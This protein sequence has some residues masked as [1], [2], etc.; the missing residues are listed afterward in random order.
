MPENKQELEQQAL[1]L[2]I[3]FMEDPFQFTPNPQ[4]DM[5]RLEETTNVWL[6]KLDEM[7]DEN[8]IQDLAYHHFLL[9][10][11]DSL[12]KRYLL[13]EM[14]LPKTAALQRI[15]Q[16]WQNPKIIASQVS[17][18]TSNSTEIYDEISEMTYQL[19]PEDIDYLKEEDWI[20]GIAIPM[21]ISYENELRILMAEVL[22]ELAGAQLI[23]V[24]E[25]L[26][27][28]YNKEEVDSFFKRY[29]V[30]VYEEFYL[31][32]ENLMVEEIET[33]Y[34][35]SSL[36]PQE[37][38]VVEVLRQQ[39]F[40]REMREIAILEGLALTY[41]QLYSPN[42]R[43]PAVV[44]AAVLLTL[45]EVGS[46]GGGYYKRIGIA[47]YFDVSLSSTRKHENCLEMLF[48]DYFSNTKDDL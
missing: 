40:F 2:L 23:Q 30:D 10:E 41:F 20:F 34:Q 43:K 8:Q 25:Y 5:L 44:A 24:I 35:A 42:F 48:D 36:S 16:K 46:F 7:M 27:E 39:P 1:Q 31:A 37:E 38:A 47:R 26:T 32:L 33:T 17:K 22:N 13:K 29:A 19:K 6:A 3:D 4:E 45:N 14:N 9:F 12:W 18:V 15:L 28:S 21:P 11:H